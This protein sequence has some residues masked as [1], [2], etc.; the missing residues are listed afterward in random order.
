MVLVIYSIDDCS[1]KISVSNFD[2]FVNYGILNCKWVSAEYPI[3]QII[4]F[5]QNK[6]K[7]YNTFNLDNIS[8][9]LI[10]LE[11]NQFNS[12]DIIKQFYT[13]VQT[14]KP[15][16]QF[17][18]TNVFYLNSKL[19]G[20]ILDSRE[21]Y[22]HWID[23]LFCEINDKTPGVKH[24]SQ[25]MFLFNYNYYQNRIIELKRVR[26]LDV[27]F[28]RKNTL[29]LNFDYKIYKTYL[30]V[31]CLINSY[32]T[33]EHLIYHYLKYNKKD[34]DEIEYLVKNKMN[35][36]IVTKFET[37]THN[38]IDV[39]YNSI[40]ISTDF[41]NVS[42]NITNK[43]TF[44][45]ACLHQ[46][47]LVKN[48]E[49]PEIE[50]N[51]RNE[52]V[53]IEF[54][55]F[56]HLEFL[57]RNMLLKLPNWSHTVICGNNNYESMKQCCYQIS[58][59]IRII[60]LDINNLSPSDYSELLTSSNFWNHFHGEKLLIYQ[61]DSFLFHSLEIETFMEYD[62]VGAPWN[63]IQDDNSYGVGNGGFSLRSK[64]IM[65]EVIGKVLP[66]SLVIGQFTKKYITNTN[67]YTLPE[68][69]Y[70]TKS[71]IDYNIGKVAPRDVALRF[72]Q[73]SINGINPI[74]GHNFF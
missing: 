56:D 17:A 24:F 28:F 12:I 44:R 8:K 6:N 41:D 5:V 53:L 22:S 64:S 43:E 48:I 49:I 30:N 74:G 20:P 13:Y 16:W 9:E 34:Y 4:L 23:M 31:R 36:K 46:L 60:K 45:E 39:S 27:Y 33:N 7:F 51:C 67:S 47:L 66:K 14:S 10:V 59:S 11:T 1:D 18:I 70:F 63:K 73:E 52:T 55:W 37:I 21:V 42:I 71:M 62:Y 32:D 40:Q 72:S 38:V 19:I 25:N 65:L 69:V 50:E 68:D 61:E 35:N 54:R 15:T 57:L 2:Y 29:P 58:K 3:T 26:D